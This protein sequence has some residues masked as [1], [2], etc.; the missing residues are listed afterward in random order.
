MSG[1]IDRFDSADFYDCD[2]GAERLTHRE[3]YE[4]IEAYLDTHCVPEPGCEYLEYPE[5]LNVY[6]WKRRSIQDADKQWLA[7]KLFD[8]LK[9]M[10]D[11]SELADPEEAVKI[12]AV[13]AMGVGSALRKAVDMF[14]ENVTIWG[15][16]Q[17]AERTYTEA[18][19]RAMFDD[20]DTK[21]NPRT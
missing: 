15:C 2:D 19:M 18:E 14:Y 1:S 12:S 11:E 8:A 4:A 20:T 7:D 13:A 21:E 16:E 5:E 10:H 9:E 17:I 6:A 3:P